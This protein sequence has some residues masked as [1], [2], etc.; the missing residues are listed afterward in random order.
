MREVINKSFKTIKPKF[1]YDVFEDVE[2]TMLARLHSSS[3]V[4]MITS[5]AEGFGLPPLEAMVWWNSSYDD[6]L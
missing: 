5:Y 4:F 1:T 3:V 2:D 6:G